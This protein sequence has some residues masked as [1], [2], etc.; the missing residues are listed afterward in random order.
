MSFRSAPEGQVTLMRIFASVF[1]YFYVEFLFGFVTHILY[2]F[3]GEGEA[4]S[5]S[6]VF[7][8][9]FLVAVT[10]F[11]D[12]GAYFI[13]TLIGKHKMI[14]HISPKKTWQGFGGA[15]AGANLAAFGMLWL[16]GEHLPGLT[17][18][19]AAIL[20]VC[21][22]CAAVAGDLAESVLKRCF[23]VKD[24]GR[25]LPGIGGALD[26]IDSILFTA[27]ILY[28]FLRIVA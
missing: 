18:A 22:G 21:L 17:A 27:P 2:F 20:A 9:I 6:G 12:M 13:G 1:A 23:A 14:P 24:S 26:L 19:G 11:T 8:V 3:G 5:R 7:Y 4:G 16:F 10:K 28:V 25:F 15:I